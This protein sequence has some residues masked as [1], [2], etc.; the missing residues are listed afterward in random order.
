MQTSTKTTLQGEKNINKEKLYT[1]LKNVK[2]NSVKEELKFSYYD[3]VEILTIQKEHPEM[4]KAILKKLYLKDQNESFFT[5]FIKD[6]LA[7]SLIIAAQKGYLDIVNK[8]IDLGIEINSKDK[9]NNVKEELKPFYYD[10]VEI[11][12]IQKE[13]PE[14]LE[15]MLRKLFSELDLKNQNN[16]SLIKEV[17]KD[18]L[19]TSLTIAAQ[20]GHLDTVNKL[21]DLGIEINSKDKDNNVKEELKFSY[22]DIVEI[23][24]I[25]KEHPEMLETILEKLYLKNQNESFFTSFIKDYLAISL[26]IAAQKGYLDIVNKLIDLGIEINS[27]DKNNCTALMHASFF[28]NEKV[29]ERLINSKA[30]VNLKNTEGSTALMMVATKN[31]RVYISELLLEKM[32]IDDINTSDNNGN[33][34]LIIAANSGNKQMVNTLIKKKGIKIN[35]CNKDG[36]TALIA[37]A[38]KGCTQTVSTLI[39]EGA[40]VNIKDKDGYTALVYSSAFRH[41]DINEML[42]NKG[43]TSLKQVIKQKIIAEL[44]SAKIIKPMLKENEFYKKNDQ[45]KILTNASRNRHIYTVRKTINTQNYL[46]QEATNAAQE[47]GYKDVKTQLENHQEEQK[48]YNPQRSKL[49]AFKEA[50]GAQERNYYQPTPSHKVK[51][52]SGDHQ[53]GQKSYNPQRSKLQAFKEAT[54]AQERNY[55]QP[56]P[57]HKVKFKSGDHQEGQQSHNPQRSKSQDFEEAVGANYST[58]KLKQATITLSNKAQ[59]FKEATGAQERNYYQPIPSHKVKFKSGDHQE[60]QQSH[61]LQRSK[62]QDFEEAVGAN[63]RTTFGDSTKKLKQ[64]TT[65]ALVK[66]NVTATTEKEDKFAPSWLQ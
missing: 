63:Y 3:I 39:T 60:G 27:K 49:Q 31:N 29:T 26:T 54:G 30:D 51:F 25:Q 48:S 44:E 17:K 66:C 55:Y 41:Y 11:L 56:I 7:I 61:N 21:I 32:T 22:Y 64:A 65:T 8:L 1:I 24:T 14:M 52:K 9:D 62:S 13:H 28:G 46:F 59:A 34:A 4:L 10:I 35:L 47:S 53:E 18:Y 38:Q 37:A 2:D 15:E 5:S 33:T 42:T 16:Q 40:E 45:Y 23:L 43:A 57:S 36:I 12:T 6:Y 20:K 19:A 50:T 58:K